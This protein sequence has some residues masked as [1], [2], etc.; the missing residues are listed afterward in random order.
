MKNI[1]IVF[2]FCFLL[3]G[4]KKNLDCCKNLTDDAELTV[5]YKT[6]NGRDIYEASDSLPYRL[7]LIQH[8][9]LD[10]IGVKK[11]ARNIFLGANFPTYPDYYRFNG[12]SSS[13]TIFICIYKGEEG[14]HRFTDFI[15]LN[16]TDTDT[17]VSDVLITNEGYTISAQKIWYNDSLVYNKLEGFGSQNIVIVK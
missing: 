12:N 15:E 7:S 4:C 2:V 8:F 6:I 1:I 3:L 17:I 13:L 16:P 9:F 14:T 11:N 5:T 10:S